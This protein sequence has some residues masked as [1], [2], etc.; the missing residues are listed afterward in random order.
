MFQLQK[1]LK[2]CFVTQPFGVNYLDFY[3]KL[4]LDGHN[5]L[6][7]RSLDGT[8]CY[9]AHDAIVLWA[10]EYE[11]YGINVYL[12]GGF[13]DHTLRPRTIYAHLQD[14]VV[15][16]GDQV[17]VGQLIGHTDNTGKYTT[18]SHLHFGLQF[19][20]PDGKVI[21]ED[22]GFKGWVDPTSYLEKYDKGWN[23]LPV[24]RRY[25]RFYNPANPGSRPW[26]AYLNEI[27]VAGA[28]TKYLKRLPNNNEIKAACYGGWDR[29]SISNP[30]LFPIWAM[31]KKDDFLKGA[32][33][34]FNLIKY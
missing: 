11:G 20:N 13:I 30:A 22:N 19:V 21:D 6:D 15:K 10:G 3:L 7:L 16:K 33:P 27:K 14:V 31:L 1:P 23:L 2:V 29:E 28:L 8:D 24:E 4:G 32:K 9:A 34:A 25:E 17:K 5:A 26:Q 18:G 12:E